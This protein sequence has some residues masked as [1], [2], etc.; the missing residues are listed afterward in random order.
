MYKEIIKRLPIYKGYYGITITDNR[1]KINKV[2]DLDYKKLYALSLLTSHK[3]YRM[4]M[5]VFNPFG[6]VKI[7]GAQI[8]HE[9]VHGANMIFEANGIEYDYAKDEPFAY[10]AE[11][12]GKHI[13]KF[14]KRNKIKL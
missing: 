13:F 4:V 3:G 6:K 8:V 2:Y 11:Y 10:L 12:F 5:F 1:K 14:F 7:N 9:C